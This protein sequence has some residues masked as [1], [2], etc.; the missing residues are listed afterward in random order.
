[1]R[2]YFKIVEVVIGVTPNVIQGVPDHGPDNSVRMSWRGA[3]IPLVRE[4]PGDTSIVGDN[5]EATNGQTNGDVE[6]V[7]L[8]GAYFVMRQ[9]DFPE[10]RVKHQFFALL[11]MHNC[12][13]T[14]I[15]ERTAG[16]DPRAVRARYPW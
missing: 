8:G 11:H 9:G 12:S 4:V 13:A 6:R 14:C 15:V 7:Q 5:R 10:S 3:E 2:R 1:M 16:P